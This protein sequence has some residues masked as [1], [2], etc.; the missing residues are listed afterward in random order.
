MYNI[1]VFIY[2]IYLFIVINFPYRSGMFLNFQ[3][4]YASL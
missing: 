2:L 3:S 4:K 1:Y